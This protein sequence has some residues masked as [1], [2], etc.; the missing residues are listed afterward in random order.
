MNTIARCGAYV[1][2]MLCFG[3]YGSGVKGHCDLF[4][5]NCD[6][7]NRRFIFANLAQ[8]PCRLAIR[9]RCPRPLAGRR[10]AAPQRKRRDCA[11]HRE[12]APGA[13]R[14]RKPLPGRLREASQG[15]A[16]QRSAPQAIRRCRA[17]EVFSHS[18]LDT[19]A[20]GTRLMVG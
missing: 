11:T 5:R 12:F 13:G 4:V 7:R 2:N 20:A 3:R 14:N 18:M 1:R 9:I 16:V 19:G 17:A 15:A 10:N 8:S 6:V